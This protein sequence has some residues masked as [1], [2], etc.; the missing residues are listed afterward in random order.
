MPMGEGTE[1]YGTNSDE[2]VNEDYCKYCFEKGEFT[3]KGKMEEMIEICVPHVVEANKDMNE[4]RARKMMMEFFPTLKRWVTRAK[5]CSK[6][7]S[8]SLGCSS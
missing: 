6:C 8:S 1:L 2:S 5:R 3:F 4:D 7:S